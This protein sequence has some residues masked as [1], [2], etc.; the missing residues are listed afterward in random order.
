[1]FPHGKAFFRRKNHVGRTENM[2]S[3]RKTSWT[4]EKSFV[5]MKNR[6]GRTENDVGSVFGFEKPC[7]G[8][9]NP[10]FGVEARIFGIENFRS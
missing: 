9:E 3:R 1:M 2:F 10:G 6:V 4:H 5:R 7:F 8:V